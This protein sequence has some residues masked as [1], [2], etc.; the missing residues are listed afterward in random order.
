MSF[1]SRWWVGRPRRFPIG[2][3]ALMLL[4]VG[5]AGCY[6]A[7][8]E[9]TALVPA[10]PFGRGEVSGRFV[11][12][13]GDTAREIPVGPA[14]V[15][16]AV[17]LSVEVERGEL[18]LELLSPEGNPVVAA[19]ARYGRHGRANGVVLTDEAGRLHYRLLA[20]E[21]GNGAYSIRYR[22]T[23]LPTPTPTPPPTP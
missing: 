10:D 19:T 14:S 1:L 9:R 23:W 15:L 8:G 18:T 11:S 20:R 4:L 7:S 21:A 3:I 17:E 13:D 12:A 22:S 5:T 16:V 2:R 6:L